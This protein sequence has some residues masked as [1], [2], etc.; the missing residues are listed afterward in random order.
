MS[1]ES[2]FRLAF[3]FVFAGMLAMQAFFA[4][5]R[6]LAGEHVPAEREA[7]GREGPGWA[8]VRAI[9]SVALV[10]FLVLYAVHPSWLGALSVPLPDL[11]RWMGIPLGVA[12]LAVYAWSRA[13]L[14]REWSSP[15]E[16]R[17]QH[18]L[19]TTGPYAWIRHPIYLALLSFMASLALVSASWLFI[20]LLL[21]SIVDL[22][23]RIPNE[24][25]M[26]SEEFGDEYGA[27]KDRTG[28]LFPRVKP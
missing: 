23:L 24:E 4:C 18:R 28:R 26:M 2:L 6:R 9:R 27:Y 11:M 25:Q 17:Q 22:T 15:L 13:T 5:R 3:W 16:M 20:A 12:S 21:F 1:S 10:A 19:V 8:I 14:G 7:R